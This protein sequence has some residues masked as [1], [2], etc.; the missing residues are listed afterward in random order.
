MAR[1]WKRPVSLVTRSDGKGRLMRFDGRDHSE[2]SI[3]YVEG[4][5]YSF[6]PSP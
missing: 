3:D 5:L 2:K 4:A 6:A 1:V